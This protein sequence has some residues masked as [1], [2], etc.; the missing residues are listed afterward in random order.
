MGLR[1]K[2]KPPTLF[3][4]VAAMM[5]ARGGKESGRAANTTAYKGA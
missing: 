1:N 5:S 3:T 4:G 2:N